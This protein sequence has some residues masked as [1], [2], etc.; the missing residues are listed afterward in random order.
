MSDLPHLVQVAVHAPVHSGL[1]DLL[2]YASAAPLPPGTLVR[3]PLGAREVLGVVWDAAAAPPAPGVELRAVAG[4]L[5]GLAPLDAHW[6]RLVAFTARYYQ[7]SL[8][9]VALAALP[10]QLRSLSTEQIARR[11]RR[12]SPAP[13][14]AAETIENVVLSAEQESARAK[15]SSEPGLFCCLAARAAARPR[16]ICAAYRRRSRQRPTR[17]RW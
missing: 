2:S 4:V 1:G 16:S 12:S 3:V 5:E 14:A 17:R 11:L 15:I 7:R 8:G 13:E 6:R 10:P 9:E